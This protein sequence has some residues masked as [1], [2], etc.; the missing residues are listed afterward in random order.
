MKGIVGGSN[1]FWGLLFVDNIPLPREQGVKIVWR[2]TGS[3]P[4]QLAAYGPDGTRVLPDW[5]EAH[6]TSSW[7]THPGYEWGSGFTFPRAGCWEVVATRSVGRPCRFARG[8]TSGPVS[9]A[10]RTPT[11]RRMPVDSRNVRVGHANLL[12]LEP[13]PAARISFRRTRRRAAIAW[14]VA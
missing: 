6:G 14:S 3:G 8:L 2:M 5:L 9:M 4:L 12:S 13:R 7:N 1:Q 11:R 10:R